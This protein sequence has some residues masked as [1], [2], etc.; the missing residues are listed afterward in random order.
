MNDDG[1]FFVSDE[2]WAMSYSVFLKGQAHA[3]LASPARSTYIVDSLN[4]VG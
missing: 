3:I 4:L 1:I 2:S